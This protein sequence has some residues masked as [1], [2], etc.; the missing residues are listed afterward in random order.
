MIV[1]LS[2][3]GLDIS[4]RRLLLLGWLLSLHHYPSGLERG[5]AGSKTCFPI[6]PD[7]DAKGVPPLI[8]RF[9]SG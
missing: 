2:S 1:V 6:S 4:M 5:A 8:A 3:C 7:N 9:T